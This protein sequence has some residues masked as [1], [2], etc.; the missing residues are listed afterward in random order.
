MRG[1]RVVALDEHPPYFH[2]GSEASLVDVVTHY[3]RIRA[4][5]LTTDRQRELV[6]Y[7]KSL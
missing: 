3:N 4:L 7:L 5:G 1:D 2:D 6:E